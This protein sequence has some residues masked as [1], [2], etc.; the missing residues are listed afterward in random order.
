VLERVLRPPTESG[1]NALMLA[2]HPL[3]TSERYP[4]IAPMDDETC[5]CAEH[6]IQ[7]IAFVCT[8]II[9]ISGDETVGFNSYTPEGPDDL[10]D[11]WCDECDAYL[12]SRGGDWAEGSV[13]VPGGISVICAECYRERERDAER[14]GRRVIHRVS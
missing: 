14:V 1:F 4:I 12:Q 11:A 10:R 13:E 5:D 2:S 6:G 7:P 8:H 3:R 9:G